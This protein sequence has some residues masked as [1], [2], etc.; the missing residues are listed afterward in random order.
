MVDFDAL[1]AELRGLRDSVAGV[2]DTVV[3][4]VDGNCIFADA[5][6][7]IDPAKISALAA[8]DLGIARQ[9]SELAGQGSLNQTVAFSS[10]SYLAV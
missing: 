2:P 8:A 5:D 4:A 3:A 9:A 1:A 7:S 6:E 10:D